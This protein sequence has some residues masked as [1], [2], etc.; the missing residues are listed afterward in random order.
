MSLSLPLQC[1]SLARWRAVLHA[2][3]RLICCLYAMLFHS[4][5]FF[6]TPQLTALGDRLGGW[7]SRDHDI[8]IRLW[9]QH[10][11]P[12]A[13]GGGSGGYHSRQK[14]NQGE[15]PVEEETKENEKEKKERKVLDLGSKTAYLLRR[16]LAQAV[17][18]KSEEEIEEH[19]LW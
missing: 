9:T 1:G 15:P 14:Q 18:M 7:D 4:I 5:L 16:R 12:A 2:T 8:F 6:T 19:L 10:V 11:G 3:T 17:Q 13:S